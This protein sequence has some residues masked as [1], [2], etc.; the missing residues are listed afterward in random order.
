[1]IIF[2]WT[3]VYNMSGGSSSNIINIIAYLV[4]KP[5][6]LNNYDANIKR[7]SSIDWSGNSYIL[8]PM[9]IITAR[10]GI[11][12]NDLAQY[13]ALAS[14]RNLAE[15]KTTK[16]ATLSTME[17]PVDLELLKNNKLLT[18]VDDTIFFCWEETRH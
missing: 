8:N 13:V 17:S 14:F 18:I 4:I 12:I 1:M 3:K 15:Y 6:P 2:D 11:G 9:P 10:K 5:L 7:L 16:R